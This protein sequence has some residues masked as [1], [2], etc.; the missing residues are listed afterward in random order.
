[1]NIFCGSII[2]KLQSKIIN[3]YIY[4]ALIWLLYGN[5]KVKSLMNIFCG[6]HIS[7]LKIKQ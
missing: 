1:M 7:N 3:E 6:Y 2:W 5:Y 4:V